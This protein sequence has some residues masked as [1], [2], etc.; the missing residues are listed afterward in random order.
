MRKWKDSFE[1]EILTS[2]KEKEDQ[3]FDIYKTNPD[4]ARQM[5]TDLTNDY[6]EKLITETKEKLNKINTASR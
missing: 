6:A 3:I 5:L 1:N 2:L 4:K